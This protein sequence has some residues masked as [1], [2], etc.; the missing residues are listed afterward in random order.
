MRFLCL[1]LSLLF[2]SVASAAEPEFILTITSGG[3]RT[4]RLP[5]S[6]EL[7]ADVRDGHWELLVPSSGLQI[8]AQTAGNRLVFQQPVKWAA[9]SVHSFE[10]RAA[11]QPK[12]TAFR[13]NNSHGDL[14]LSRNDEPVLNYNVA[15]DEPPSGLDRLYRKSGYFHPVYSPAGNVLTADFPVDHAHQHG[16]FFA[17]VKTTIAGHPIDFWNQ[18]RGTGT[19]LHRELSSSQQGNEFASF[20]AE[21]EH[22]MDPTADPQTA[23]QEQWSVN[24]FPSPTFHIWELQS[25]QRNV[26]DVPVTLEKYHYGGMAFRGSVDWILNKDNTECRMLTSEGDNREQ[27]NHK[28]ARWVKIS[29]PATDGKAQ[30]SR[31]GLVMMSHPE[32]A[33]SPQKVRLHPTKPYFCFCPVVDEQLILEPGDVFRSRYL[34]VTF[35]GDPEPHEL[36]ELWSDYACELDVKLD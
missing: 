3:E 16:I 4:G 18:A 29:G 20:S 31:C 36:E 26:L 10:M 23:L 6:I 32:N 25:E 34:M 28:A 2:S 5:V 9:G 19:I 12:K 30:T 22:L 7:P 13:W 21:L 15:I 11:E 8:S 1:C 17:W 35:D 14:T 27:G 24:A 33:R